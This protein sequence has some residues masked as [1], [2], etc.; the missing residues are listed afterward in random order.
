MRKILLVID[1]Y[2]DLVAT[3]NFLRRLGFDVLSVGKDVLVNDAL[4]RFHPDIVV[5]TFKSRSVDGLKLA[6]KLKKQNSAIMFALVHTS[7]SPPELTV[8]DENLVDAFIELPLNP[9]EAIRIVAKLAQINPEPLLEKFEKL[10]G[11]RLNN[12]DGVVIVGKERD[13][14]SAAPDAWSRKLDTESGNRQKVSWDPVTTPG[15]AAHAKSERSNR[16]DKFLASN[17]IPVANAVL[18]HDRL[19]A[20]MKELA[21]QALSEK[22]KLKEI[23]VHKRAF[24]QALFEIEK[25]KNR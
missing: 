8:A 4:G 5:S 11:A 17:D 3:E 24:A 25:K 15:Q 19:K 23:D 13:R 20:S 14:G 22:D 1:E 7:S 9:N 16:Y 10:A 12:G 6:A 18:P 2:R 21:E